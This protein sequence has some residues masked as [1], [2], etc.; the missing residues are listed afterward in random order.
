MLI[1]LPF[2][3]IRGPPLRGSGSYFINSERAEPS[4]T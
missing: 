3:E 2:T 4:P 1:L